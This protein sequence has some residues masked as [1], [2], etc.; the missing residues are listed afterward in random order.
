MRPCG[1]TQCLR[2]NGGPW[3]DVPSARD[4]QWQGL[5][6]TVRASDRAT[7]GFCA[8]CGSTLFWQADG[9]EPA[10]SHGAMD[11]A[12]GWRLLAVEYG[13]TMPDAFRVVGH[14]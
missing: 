13:G 6:A 7:R 12:S 10:L 8:R 1:C 2:Q 4:I 5:P 14:G 3:F 11:D 9:K